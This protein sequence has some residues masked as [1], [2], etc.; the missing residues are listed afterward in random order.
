MNRT[1]ISSP[2]ASFAVRRVLGAM[3]AVCLTLGLSVAFDGGAAPAVAS[4]FPPPQDWLDGY[5]VLQNV[6]HSHQRLHVG[7]NADGR[8][9]AEWGDD[10]AYQWKVIPT[11]DGH[12]VFLENGLYPQQRL[13]VGHDGNGQLYAQSGDDDA[14][15]WTF[16][17]FGNAYLLRNKL[18][19]QQRLHV[20]HDGNGQLYAQ[21]GDDDAY[22]WTV[23]VLPFLGAP[24]DNTFRFSDHYLS[25]PIRLENRYFNN[26]ALH[27]GH[28]GNGRLYAGSGDDPAY[29]WRIETSAVD[30]FY[31]LRNELHSNQRLHVG[32]NGNGQLYAQWGSDDAYLWQFEPNGWQSFFLRNR[33]HSH[34]RLHVGHDGNGQ[35]Y[36]EWGD[37]DTYRWHP[38]IVEVPANWPV[39]PAS[40]DEFLPFWDVHRLCFYPWPN[41]QGE[42][43]CA[44]ETVSLIVPSVQKRD[45]PTGVAE[46]ARS[47][48][49]ESCDGNSTAAPPRIFVY[50]E[51]G[52][53]SETD[54]VTGSGNL[55][56]TSEHARSFALQPFDY[57]FYDDK[58]L[59][60]FTGDNASGRRHCVP[61]EGSEELK[62][63]SPDFN[64]RVRSVRAYPDWFCVGV[65]LHEHYNGGGQWIYVGA[66]ENLVNRPILIDFWTQDWRTWADVTSSFRFLDVAVPPCDGD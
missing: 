35:L 29:F 47:V 9:Y 52:Q 3:L 15:R 41:Q 1:T 11:G 27:V 12:Y 50:R 31:Y 55:G 66:S 63:L 48:S 51:T 13:H 54:I 37:D 65:D 64:D 60:F 32:H 2:T 5:I 38:R 21:W 53:Q 23:Q 25:K 59:C 8:L 7:H 18:H 24:V 46:N 44:R 19:S 17:P 62:N 14:F 4:D 33:M 39:D 36:A 6:R 42:P 58:Y 28:D 43:W 16:E 40:C 20:G 49:I 26:Q 57:P 10:L 22:R 34:Q 45:L 56:A 30:G 61:F